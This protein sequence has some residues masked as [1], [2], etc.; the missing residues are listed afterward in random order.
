MLLFLFHYCCLLLLY[1]TGKVQT[2]EI[3]TSF[4]L[5]LLFF[6]LITFELSLC[7]AGSLFL[8]SFFSTLYIIGKDSQEWQPHLLPRPFS[9]QIFEA[10][11]QKR[12][13]HLP[14][15][16]TTLSV[17]P[18][19]TT[20]LTLASKAAILLFLQQC[21]PQTPFPPSSPSV[22]QKDSLK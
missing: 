13:L 11:S 5:H 18:S 3:K 10:V 21:L 22:V 14:C 6:V 4:L 9:P 19:L 1:D 7:P 20:E 15:S 16:S 17:T 2:P 12:Y 8:I